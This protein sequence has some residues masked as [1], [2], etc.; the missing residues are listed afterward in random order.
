MNYLDSIFWGL[1]SRKQCLW[2]R[3]CILPSP[4]L[5][6]VTVRKSLSS[7]QVL[8]L[9]A[10]TM[11]ELTGKTFGRGF[12]E[13]QAS[14][15]AICQIRRNTCERDDSRHVIRERQGP[16][17]QFKKSKSAFWHD[18]KTKQGLLRGIFSLLKVMVIWGS[19]FYPKCLSKST[20]I[21]LCVLIQNDG[22]LISQQ[23]LRSTA[24]W[25]ILFPRVVR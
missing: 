1:C 3:V 16:S 17:L 13:S 20:K 7:C 2:R 18:S 12:W 24:Q 22:C 9:Q 15:L 5:P 14:D 6:R 4:F 10:K 8:I 21:Y 11:I 19:V 25:L 23:G